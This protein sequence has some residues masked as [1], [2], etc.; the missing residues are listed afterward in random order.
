MGLKQKILDA[1]EP[2]VKNSESVK[3]Q[4]DKIPGFAKKLLSVQTPPWDNE[5]QFL[6]EPDQTIQ[7]YF[8]LDSINFCFWQITDKEKWLFPKC[9]DWIS[10]YYAL[11]Y[12]LKQAALNNPRFLKADYL[13]SISFDEFAEVLKGKG[14]LLLIS[15]R[16]K[17]VNENFAILKAKYHG[18]AKNLL[19]KAG[20]NA[21]KLVELILADFPTFRDWP[22]L[23]RAQ[24]FVADIDKAL[25]ELGL[26]GL[27]ELTVFADYKLP[28]LLQAEGVLEYTHELKDK[29]AKEEL[30]SPGSKP[31]TE[32]RANTVWACELIGEELE[33]LGRKLSSSELD[34]I[35]WVLAKETKF[36]LPYHKT[37]TILY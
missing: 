25:P 18:Q 21:S 4:A 28:Q 27:D 14:E 23:K 24:I 17:I 6:G 9:N 22:F 5:L 3:I 34:W 29:I 15:E 11:S 2:M 37:S 32:I 33:K 7:Y 36:E 30:I 1:I 16:H 12:A 13:S 8:L 19:A 26:S 20:N 31:E 35:L 10:G